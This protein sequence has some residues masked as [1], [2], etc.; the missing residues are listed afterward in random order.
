LI[1]ELSGDTLPIFEPIEM[2]DFDELFTMF[3]PLPE[4]FP[5]AALNF[6]AANSLFDNHLLPEN[7]NDLNLERNHHV[8]REEVYHRGLQWSLQSL[9]HN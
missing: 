2:N 9:W 1:E 8:S 6:L 7:E 4:I 3:P 5:D